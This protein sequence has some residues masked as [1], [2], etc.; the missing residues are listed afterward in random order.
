MLICPSHTYTILIL[1]TLYVHTPWYINTIYS[2]VY[3]KHTLSTIQR[4]HLDIVHSIHTILS[5][6]PLYMY[7][8]LNQHVYIIWLLHSYQ[9]Y[10]L[11]H[12]HTLISYLYTV[13]ISIILYTHISIQRILQQPNTILLIYP[14]KSIHTSYSKLT[15]YI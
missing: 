9:Y 12:K 10:I 3:W 13:I 5:I 15:M 2:S 6:C 11:I 8:I 14:Y 1:S 4:Q 7:T